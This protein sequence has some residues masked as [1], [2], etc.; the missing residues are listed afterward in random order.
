MLGHFLSIDVCSAPR[1]STV[2]GEASLRSSASKSLGENP[3]CNKAQVWS[4]QSACTVTSYVAL[5]PK[6]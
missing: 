6:V 5:E 4:G 1:S 2:Y 3:W